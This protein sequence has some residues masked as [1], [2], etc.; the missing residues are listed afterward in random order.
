MCLTKL[1]QCSAQL[2]AGPR[3]RVLLNDHISFCFCRHLYHWCLMLIMVFRL[4][5]RQLLT[6]KPSHPP[7]HYLSRLHVGRYI[8]MQ[9]GQVSKLLPLNLLL[10]AHSYLSVTVSCSYTPPYNHSPNAAFYWSE[11]SQSDKITLVIYKTLE[12]IYIRPSL[13]WVSIIG[14]PWWETNTHH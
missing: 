13:G 1:T 14:L 3:P 12:Y 10:H 2:Y 7:S 11:S 5:F 6:L 4:L 8:Y 9:K